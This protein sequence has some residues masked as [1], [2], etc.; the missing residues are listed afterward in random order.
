MIRHPGGDGSDD[1]GSAVVEF[2][3]VGLL[4]LV[5]ILYLV[6]AVGRVQAAVLA[7][8]AASRAAV[9]AITSADSED[10]GR[11]TAHSLVR[12]ALADQ[13]FDIDPDDAVTLE[14]PAA[15]CL[16][17]GGRVAVTVGFTVSLPG[18]PVL[19]G[20]DPVGVPVSATHVGSIDEFRAGD[21][22]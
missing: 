10:A 16:T 2:V 18:M 22:P 7:T 13:G 12:Y 11:A 6:L 19:P 15:G 21:P 5:P 17:P 4:L 8:E 14:C 1:R 20:V 9:R 3:T